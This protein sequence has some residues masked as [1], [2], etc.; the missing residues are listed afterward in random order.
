M[1]NLK[2]SGIVEV[3][4]QVC[5]FIKNTF[6]CLLFL[7][8]QIGCTANNKNL[9]DPNVQVFYP[10]T[11][12]IVTYNNKEVH[13][14]SKYISLNKLKQIMAEN[15]EF[16]I[17]FSSEK[18]SACIL[19]HKA[20]KQA[21]LKTEVYYL[22]LDE[23]WV[24]QVAALMGIDSVPLMLHIDKKGNTIAQKLGPGKIVTYLLI[25]F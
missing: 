22:N 7:I 21:E 11:E 25:R 19:T 8:L 4:V 23:K 10:E 5:N 12:L 24:M 17:I 13:R 1:K 18:C 2:E 14:V 9:K 6:F 3:F 20:I 16:I 15:K